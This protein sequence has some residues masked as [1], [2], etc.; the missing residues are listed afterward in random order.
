MEVQVIKNLLVNRT[1]TKY[2]LL[3]LL[4]WKREKPAEITPSIHIH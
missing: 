4:N 3:T 1:T 2:I